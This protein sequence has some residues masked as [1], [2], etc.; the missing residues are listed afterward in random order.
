MKKRPK[1]LPATHSAQPVD[2][3]LACGLLAA[4]LIGGTAITSYA[5]DSNRGDILLFLNQLAKSI[6]LLVQLLTKTEIP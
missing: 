2:R 5:A 3:K 1:S 4:A 6:P